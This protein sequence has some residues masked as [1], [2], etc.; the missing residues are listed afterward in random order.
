MD[1]VTTVEQEFLST[2][3]QL[4][5]YANCTVDTKNYKIMPVNNPIL[6]QDLTCTKIIIG[7]LHSLMF[8]VMAAQIYRMRL[9]MRHG[10]N[11]NS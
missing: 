10:K 4:K 11:C 2:S 5:N 3:V 6:V 8:V 9:K 1:T 7:S